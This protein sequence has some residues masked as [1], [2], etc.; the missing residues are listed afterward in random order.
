MRKGSWAAFQPAHDSHSLERSALNAAA[1]LLALV[2]EVTETSHRKDRKALTRYAWAGIPVVWI[3]DLV[4][5]TIEVHSNPTGPAAP[6][7]YR[8]TT[9]YRE[10]DEIPV[11]L[12]GREAGRLAVGE[13]LP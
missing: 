7:G 4:G 5:R 6:A 8:E 11:F 2:V 3:V 9:V 1:S 10:G 12:D 13:L